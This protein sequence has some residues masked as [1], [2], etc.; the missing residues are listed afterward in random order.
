MGFG[1]FDWSSPGTSSG[2]CGSMA[3][4]NF[5][6]P[7]KRS[8]G[9]LWPRRF[10]ERKAGSRFRSDIPQIEGKVF[11]AIGLVMEKKAGEKRRIYVVTGVMEPTYI[12]GCV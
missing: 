7:K 6:E 12:L 10:S 11:Q 5:R 8:C 2:I 9:K 4:G 3:F 1:V